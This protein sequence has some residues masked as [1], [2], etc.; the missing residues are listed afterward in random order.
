M[1][2]K[3]KKTA[4]WT[5]VINGK[6]RRNFWNFFSKIIAKNKNKKNLELKK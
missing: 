2:K 1:I 4:P 5:Y 3:V 6:W